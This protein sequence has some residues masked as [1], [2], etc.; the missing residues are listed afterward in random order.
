MLTVT[1]IVSS[2]IQGR[3]AIPSS[4]PGHYCLLHPI[5]QGC[6]DALMPLVDL[7]FSKTRQHLKDVNIS[8]FLSF[9]LGVAHAGDFFKGRAFVLY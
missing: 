9:Y 1:K 3:M 7:L 5:P 6:P 8:F 4:D 2:G